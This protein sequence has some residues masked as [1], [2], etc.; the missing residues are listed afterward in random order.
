MLEDIT[1]YNIS[2]WI[3][4]GSGFAAAIDAASLPLIAEVPY[5]MIQGMP[6]TTVHGHQPSLRVLEYGGRAVGVFLGRHHL[7]EGHNAEATCSLVRTAHECGG[8]HVI[9]TNAS[10]GLH[11][12]LSV[13]DIVLLEDG[14]DFTFQRNGA[15]EQKQVQGLEPSR[16]PAHSLFDMQWTSRTAQRCVANGTAVRT[17]LYVQVMGPSF[18][19]RAEIRMLRR[20]GADLVGMSTI[21]EAVFAAQAGMSVLG[22][23]LVANKASDT[24]TSPLSH[25]DVLDTAS[26]NVLRLSSVLLAALDCV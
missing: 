25:N 17:G 5:A 2:S 18:E 23:S 15:L 12:S 21:Q 6:T 26:I 4:A 1:R 22:I 10:G 19:T 3:V 20:M 11:P 14:I 8:K 24:T 13:G 9:L 7:Y 16:L